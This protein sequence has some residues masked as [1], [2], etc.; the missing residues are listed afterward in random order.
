MIEILNNYKVPIFSVFRSNLF[1][2]S[3]KY[4][5]SKS[6]RNLCP[7]RI[8]HDEYLE[9]FLFVFFNRIKKFKFP[10]LLR[11]IPEKKYAKKSVEQLKKN[12]NLSEDQVNSFKY[13]EETIINLF[14]LEKDKKIFKEELKYFIKKISIRKPKYPILIRSLRMHLRKI[15]VKFSN[16]NFETFN[17]ILKWME[18]N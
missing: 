18:N 8:I 12:K 9:S 2:K 14:K 15:Y 13:I 1:K 5:P 4:I 16:K 17:K 7:T 11:T 3:F 10:Y 6:N